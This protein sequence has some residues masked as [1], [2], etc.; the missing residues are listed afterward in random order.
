MRIL[1]VNYAFGDHTA[2]L[3]NELLNMKEM[4]NRGH[5]VSFVTTDVS[6]YFI[7]FK[8]KN[9]LERYDKPIDISGIPV[10]VLHSTLPKIGIYC[11]NANKLAK[12]IVKNY[13]VIHIRNWYDH[14]SITFYKIA[15]KYEIPFVF[16][17]HGTLEPIS[18]KKYMKR[19]KQIIDCMYT[20]KMLK[21]CK[22]IHAS[23]DSEV[24][25]FEK[26]GADKNKI[27]RINIGLPLEDFQINKRSEILNK[28]GIS[29]KDS[30]YILFL[31]RI[32]QKKGLDLLIKAFKKFS[33]K[34]QEISLVIVG[35]GP[36]SYE[37]EIKQLVHKLGLENRVKFL[38]FVVG[39]DKLQLLESAK[40]FALTTYSDVHPVA[41][42]EAL[43]MGLPILITKN[44][45]F[46]EI[47]EYNAGQI[48]DTDIEIISN[49]LEK[50]MGN[51]EK[52]EQYSRNA[53]KLFLERFSFKNE[54][55]DYEKLYKNAI[56]ASRIRNN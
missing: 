34:F 22:G 51:E 56:N 30:P 10:Y 24:I 14:L 48:V 28:F 3:R 19:V 27:F 46:P 50:M 12:N 32:H 15:K 23:S 37:G 38:G 20:K 26:L 31:G 17:S 21:E 5:Q 11:P 39:N 4:Q 42:V 33:E 25:E 29:N 9:N 55:N 54:P 41:V 2:A 16:T 1:N 45:D 36:K 49:T 35:N 18:R 13:D 7:D 52:L 53:K 43:A 47:E 8:K 44:G 40:L 6:Q